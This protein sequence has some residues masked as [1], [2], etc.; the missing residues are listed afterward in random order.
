MSHPASGWFARITAVLVVLS[1]AVWAGW[2]IRLETEILALFPRELPSVRGLDQF[3]RQFTSDR[4][5]ILVAE[6]TLPAT[7]REG[8]FQKLRPVLAALPGV[9]S[10]AAPGDEWLRAAPELAAWAIWN[11][12]AERFSRVVAAL[13]PGPVRARLDELPSVLTGA[14]DPEEL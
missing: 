2:T 12:P 6:D 7:A 9:E 13:G 4:E 14:L 3:Q 10:V 8:V 11:L 5:V 1:G